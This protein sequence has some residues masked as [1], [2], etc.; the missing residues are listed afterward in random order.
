MI[1]M[2]C[3]KGVEV[4][5]KQTLPTLELASRIGERRRQSSGH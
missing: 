1:E 4:E 3:V 2:V 5:F